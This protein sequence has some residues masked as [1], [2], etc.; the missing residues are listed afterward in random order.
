MTREARL[1]WFVA[2]SQSWG[3]AS[4]PVRAQVFAAEQAYAAGYITGPTFIERIDALLGLAI[5]A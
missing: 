2:F 4:E 3:R 1:G 5:P